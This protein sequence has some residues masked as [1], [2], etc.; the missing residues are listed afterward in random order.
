[1]TTYIS[2]YLLTIVGSFLSILRGAP[3]KLLAPIVFALIVLF[4]GLRYDSVDYFN[5]WAIFDQTRSLGLSEGHE[6]G[7]LAFILGIQAVGGGFFVFVFLFALASLLVKFYGYAKL[8]PY[9]VLSLLIYVS[10]P[11]IWKEM[12]QIRGA[13]AASILFVSII[14]AYER[15]PIKFGIAL[16]AATL[17]H[18]SAIVGA[19]IYFVRFGA[20]Q[21]YMLP[22]LV[23]STFI[24]ASGGIGGYIAHLA[25]LLGIVDPSSRLLTYVGSDYD[26]NLN[27]Y[28]LSSLLRIVV[29]LSMI[30]FY[31]ELTRVWSYNKT[32]VP[33]FIYGTCLFYLFSD[34]GILGSRI[35]SLFCMVPITAILPSFMLLFNGTKRMIPYLAAVA[36]TIVFLL[37]QLSTVAPYQSII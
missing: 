36:Y 2:L 22:A 29:S 27:I 17:F 30:Y 19:V 25:L 4:V 10:T 20:K 24:A 26:T 13:M 8:S 15:N 6:P 21:I 23:V 28:G 37:Y 34:Y 33:T 31:D 7:F 3:V 16:L 11:A 5:Y 14:Y 1:M 32:L 35:D 9:I 12:G 18:L